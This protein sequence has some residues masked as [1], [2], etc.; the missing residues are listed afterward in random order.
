MSVNIGVSL[1]T[2]KI[3]VAA[4]ETKETT[5]TVRNQGQIVDQFALSVEGLDPTWWTFSVPTV[6]LFPGDQGESNLIIRPPKEAEAKAGSYSFRVKATSQANPQEMTVVEAFLILR[7]FVVWEVDMS[8]TKVVGQSGK[9]RLSVTNSGNTDIT[10]VFEGKDPEEGLYYHFAPDKLTIP[11]GGSARSILS[12]RPKKGEPQK[13]YSFQVLTRLAE[14][15]VPPKDVARLQGQLEYPRAGKFPWWLL[16]LILA[17]LAAAYAAWKFVLPSLLPKPSPVTPKP[18]V[19]TPAPV[20]TITVTSPNG[21][22]SW[23]AGTTQTIRWTYTGDP[24]SYVKIELLKGGVVNRTIASSTP[25][26]T[27]GSGSFNWAIPATQTYGT[28]YK[29]RITS[30]TDALYTDTSNAVFTIFIKFELPPLRPLVPK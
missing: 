15:K 9:Y 1:S 10:L 17:L 16:L 27:A 19:V 18:S 13:Q 5:V 23:Q 28:D 4:G 25:V 24:G 29:V 8:P 7:G 3:E 11:A 21:G 26:G 6:S 22:E 2:T 30:T 20:A 12:V 14:A